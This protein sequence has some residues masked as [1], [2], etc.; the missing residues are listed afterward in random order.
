MFMMLMD[1]QEAEERRRRGMKDVRQPRA[2]TCVIDDM[3]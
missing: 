2:A 1:C 3:H